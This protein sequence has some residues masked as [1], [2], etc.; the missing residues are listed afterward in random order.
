[1]SCEVPCKAEPLRPAFQQWIQVLLC[2]QLLPDSAFLLAKLRR[3][4]AA[5]YAEARTPEQAEQEE[6]MLEELKRG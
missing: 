4:G 1:M 6:R 2:L 3:E 5:D